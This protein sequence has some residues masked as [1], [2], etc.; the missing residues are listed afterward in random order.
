MPCNPAYATF[1]QESFLP[2]AMLRDAVI[3]WAFGD[4]LPPLAVT[5]RHATEDEVGWP[6][7]AGY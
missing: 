4:V 7:G 5:W 1:P 2:I 3:Q 6:V